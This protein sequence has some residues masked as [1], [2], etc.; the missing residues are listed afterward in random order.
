MFPIQ[1]TFKGLDPSAALEARIHE[2]A[3]KLSRSDHTIQRC[4]VVVE[5]PHNHHRHGRQFHVRVHV[6]L[7]GREVDVSRDPGDAAAHEDP[8]VAVRDAF[9]AARRQLDEHAKGTRR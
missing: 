9:L 1:I 7:P 8:Y 2:L 5:S 3:D 4:E 6:A